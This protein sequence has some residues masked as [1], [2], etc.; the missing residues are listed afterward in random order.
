MHRDSLGTPTQEPSLKELSMKNAS[1]V[2]LVVMMFCSLGLWG[3]TNQKNSAYHAKIR[4]LEN[5][6]V[7]LEEDYKAMV[8]IG[9]QLR[10]KVTQLETQRT[11]LTQQVE[12]LKVISRER[13]ELRVQLSSR[14]SERDNLHGQ[15][16]LLR[17]GLQDMLGRVQT[18]LAESDAGA[19]AAVPTSRKKE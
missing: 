10:K 3:C 11:E 5:R 17:K 19:V 6:Y 4:E 2:F 1:T 9:D 18:A 7:K 14:T 16:T 8:Q 13:D 12:D 15:L